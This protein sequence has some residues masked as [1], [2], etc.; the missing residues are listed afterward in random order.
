MLEFWFCSILH[1]WVENSKNGILDKVARTESVNPG[2]AFE[3]RKNIP[4]YTRY[5]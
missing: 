2:L 1:M 4:G 5:Y 3:R